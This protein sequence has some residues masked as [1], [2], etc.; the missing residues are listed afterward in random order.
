MLWL[1]RVAMRS[2][3]VQH[4]C[5]GCDSVS[6]VCGSRN[7]SFSELHRTTL[8]TYIFAARVASIR[9][10]E[11]CIVDLQ[12]SAHGRAKAIVS[13]QHLNISLRAFTAA[14]SVL[15]TCLFV[16]GASEATV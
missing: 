13:T 14:P 10:I 7:L 16:G 6:S 12:Q 3:D 4:M 11:H 5:Y 15:L 2:G 1:V 8:L 9:S